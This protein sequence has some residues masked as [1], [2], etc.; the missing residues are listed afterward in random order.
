[1]QKG[2]IA[3]EEVEKTQPI[4]TFPENLLEDAVFDLSSPSGNAQEY[5]QDRIF[6]G[7][8][9]LIAGDFNRG[10]GFD[11][12]FLLK[13]ALESGYGRFITFYFAARELPL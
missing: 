5:Q 13:L 12:E 4:R 6:S 11:T 1:M 10:F 2:Y 3:F 9:V 7:V 8:G